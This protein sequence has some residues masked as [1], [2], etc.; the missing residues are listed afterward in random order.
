MDAHP[1]G[2]KKLADIRQHFN[3]GK[4]SE[5]PLTLRNYYFDW[6]EYEIHN[7]PVNALYQVALQDKSAEI[8]RKTAELLDKYDKLDK[9]TSNALSHD[10]D[11]E[12][13]YIA[14]KKADVHN[15]FKED[16]VRVVKTSSATMTSIRNACPTGWKAPTVGFAYKRPSCPMTARWK[17][18]SNDSNRQTWPMCWTLNLGGRPVK[19]L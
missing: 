1:K 15:F 3:S 5:L 4:L 6:G 9:E 13:R 18:C 11:W 16:D 12:V 8:R 7:L 17:K 2:E 14:A 10:K 19:S